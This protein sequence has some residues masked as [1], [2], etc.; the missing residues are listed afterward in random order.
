M[1][2]ARRDPPDRGMDFLIGVAAIFWVLLPIAII[3][4]L[5][6]RKRAEISWGYFV[7]GVISG[8]VSVPVLYYVAVAL[9]NLDGGR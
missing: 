4:E 1:E 3:V 5:V 6:R 2:Q 8:V 7:G 9:V